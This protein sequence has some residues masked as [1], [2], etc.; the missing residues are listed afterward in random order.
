MLQGVFWDCCE[1]ASLILDPEYI[2]CYRLQNLG[3]QSWFASPVWMKPNKSW[4][5]TRI[6]ERAGVGIIFKTSFDD[7]GDTLAA[8]RDGVSVQ[9]VP[10]EEPEDLYK[11]PI[12]GNTMAYLGLQRKEI[13][14]MSSQK[15]PCKAYQPLHSPAH[16]LTLGATVGR[17]PRRRVA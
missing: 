13:Y 2:G 11:L 6:G 7:F 10:E 5:W 9:L 14:R 3:R 16:R 17:A 4:L 12:P 8:L 15:E 1:N